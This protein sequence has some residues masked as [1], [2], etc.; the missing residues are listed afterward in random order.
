MALDLTGLSVYTDQNSTDLVRKAFLGARIFNHATVMSGIKYKEAIQLFETDAVLQA[1]GCGWSASGTT[2]LTQ[3]D[4]EVAEFKVNEGIC[5]DDLNKYW[6]QKLLNAGSYHEDLPFEAVYSEEK[7]QKV[8]AEIER[9]IMVGSVAGGDL[10]DGA[11]TKL[12]TTLSGDTV[13]GNPSS[14]TAITAS[15]IIGIVEDAIGVIPAD[16]LEEEVTMYVGYDF[17]KLYNRALRAANL[18]NNERFGDDNAPLYIQDIY[19]TNVKMVAIKPL[20]A[21]NK[22]FI[23]LEDNMRIGT[24]LES[25]WEEFK[26]FYSEDNDEVRVRMKGKFGVTFVY[27]ELVTYFKLA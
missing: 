21:T 24:D 27:P 8:A 5:P 13:D 9:Q 12:D 19:G 1:G 2:K 22:F 20:N 7:A 23:T 4:I 18:F 15:N 17:Y 26:I 16:L 3:Q 6:G 25:D 11:I 10:V 14:V